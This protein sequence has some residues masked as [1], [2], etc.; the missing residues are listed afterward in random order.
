MNPVIETPSLETERLVLR[1]PRGSDFEAWA[2]FFCSE[3]AQFVGGSSTAMRSV[4][5][6]S[7]GH[8]IGH[9]VMRGFGSF[10]M[11]DKTSGE[12]FGNVGPWY[13]EGWPEAELGWTIWTPDA[14]GK[15]YAF[16]AVSAVRDYVFED[17]NWP[18]AVSYI[19]PDN[20]RSITLAKRLGATLDARAKGPD[21]N[22]LV[23]RHPMPEAA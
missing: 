3:R 10:V 12:V 14:E 23:Y 18:T 2:A 17:L 22:D 9:W 11:E 1:G 19:D 13:P 21:D 6:R 5:W 7:F 15:G 16:E 20:S 8:L 4:A